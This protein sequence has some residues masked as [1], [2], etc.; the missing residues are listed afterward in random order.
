MP[1]PRSV[2]A[3]PKVGRAGLGNSLLPWARAEIFAARTGA[4]ILAP[5][6]MTL[7]LGPYWRGEADKRHYEA[8]FRS[9]GYIGGINKL[10]LCL[11]AR[12][13]AEN[14]VIDDMDAGRRPLVVEFSGLQELF[15]PLLGSFSLIKE[16]LWNMTIE[17][18][19]PT[20]TEYGGRFIA[21]HVRRG[22]LTRQGISAE[23]LPDVAQFT[24]TSWFVH[25]VQAVRDAP[26]LRDLPVIVFSDGY[27]EEIEELVSLPGVRLCERR[28]AIT[29]LWTM[30]RACVLFGSGFSTFTMWA[31]YLGGGPTLYAPGKMAQCVLDGRDGA[32][33][34]ELAAGDRIPAGILTRAGS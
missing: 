28:A 2:F 1:P 23:T 8:Y 24:P 20:E 27:R 17:G 16:R 6:W 26:G 19:R 10:L 12:H 33:E 11:V 32:I 7:R 4:R 25:M 18:L 14:V 21:M 29:D 34:L 31:S 5:H 3:L 15:R 9:D 30:S 22:D 13:V